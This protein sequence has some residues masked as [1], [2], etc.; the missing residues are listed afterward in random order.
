[1]AIFEPPLPD[2]MAGVT[3]L[4]CWFGYGLAATLRARRRPSLMSAVK[5]FR[6][7]WIERMC[8]RD[9]HTADATLLSNLLRGSLFLASTTV[10][11]LGGLVALLGTAPKVSEVISQLPYASGS[12]PRLAEIKALVLIFVYVYAFFKFTWSAWQYN[13]LSIMV[14]A[15]PDASNGGRVPADYQV[16][17]SRVTSLAGD[18]Y[19]NGIRAYYFSIPL[20]AWFIDPLLFLAATLIVTIV[21]YRREFHSPVLHAL[22]DVQP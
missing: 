17:A 19:N 1:M 14:G 2:I 13:I 11:I 16:A 4:L 15:M 5:V 22:N 6:R 18:S 10:F 7:R 9:N 20:M 8:E 21:I 3:F 12:E